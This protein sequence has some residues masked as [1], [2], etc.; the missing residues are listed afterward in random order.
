MI[1]VCFVFKFRVDKFLFVIE[2]GKCNQ[3][4]LELVI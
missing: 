3:D 4:D 1:S 2:G